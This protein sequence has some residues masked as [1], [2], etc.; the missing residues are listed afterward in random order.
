ITNNYIHIYLEDALQYFF[1][2]AKLPIYQGNIPL[3]FIA[4]FPQLKAG[5]LLKYTLQNIMYS[6]I[7]LN[8]L[9]Y[10]NDEN[11]YFPDDLFNK[12][13]NND[14]PALYYV[15][16]DNENVSQWIP[17]LEAIEMKLIQKT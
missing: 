11:F 13:F 10:P 12:S 1:E 2:Y 3:N 4:Y 14:I 8:D 6:Y 15:Y 5:Y 9:R 17:M 7:I 16:R